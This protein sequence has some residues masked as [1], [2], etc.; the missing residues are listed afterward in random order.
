MSDVASW[1]KEPA[2]DRVRPWRRAVGIAMIVVVVA[3]AVAFLLGMWNPWRLVL[4]QQRFANPWLG[5]AV[6]AAGSYV[7]LWLLLP[8]RNEARQR[9]RITV[10]VWVAVVAV[11]GLIVGGILSLL[12][13]YESTELARS[14]DG[15][16]AVALVVTGGLQE[17][18]LRIWEGSGWWKREVASL[19][20]PCSRVEAQ[21]AGPDTVVVNQGYGDWVFDLD[22]RTGAPRQVLGPACPDGPQPATLK[23]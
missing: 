10:R 2:S 17:R 3:L 12:Y 4:L 1:I 8:V 21:F 20:R 13:R 11:V 22:P 9:W 23:E 15:E 19:G 7:V 6:V 5:L 18:D 16:R 14:P